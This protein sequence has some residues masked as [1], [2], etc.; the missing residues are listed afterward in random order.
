MRRGEVLGL[1]WEDVDFEDGYLTVRDT[2]NR[3]D[4]QIPLSKRL[5][6]TLKSIGR[7]GEYVV[8]KADDS[9]YV[10]PKN[11]FMKAV[12]RA[13]IKH[14]RVH[15]LRHT[16]ATRLVM[17]GGDIVTVMELLGHKTL[18]M[19]KRYSHPTP[20]HKKWAVEMLNHGRMPQSCHS[21]QDD[22]KSGV[23]REMLSGFH[24]DTY[25]ESEG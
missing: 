16:V 13:G 1:K 5:I 2:K 14:C 19:T 20:E 18:A 7:R 8:C 24:S 15:D 25:E 6:Y 10:D 21:A 9:R 12:K 23:C 17:N 3:E 4:R 22:H 11:G